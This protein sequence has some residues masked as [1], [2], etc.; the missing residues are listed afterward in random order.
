MLR[1]LSLVLA[2]LLFVGGIILL[3]GYTTLPDYYTTTTYEVSYP[4]E[5]VWQK[6]VMIQDMPDRKGDVESITVLEQYGK[7]L[8]WQENLKNGGYRIY[9]MNEWL[10]NEKLVIELT[11][12]SYGLTGIWVFEL[13]KSGSE[14][15]ITITEESAL[16]DIKLRGARV[17]FG[18]DHDLLVWI[19]YIN[20]GLVQA[21]LKTL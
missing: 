18:R 16:T 7:L 15:Q 12:S 3:A 9:R 2:I 17:F 11:E 21:L 4:I 14:T 5:L 20:V 6:L 8:A 1:I 19:K 13:Q 10:D